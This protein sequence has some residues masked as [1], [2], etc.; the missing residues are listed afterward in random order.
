M[1]IKVLIIDDDPAMVD[2]LE[3]TLRSQ[4]METISACDGEK[5]ARLALNENPHIILLDLIMPG[6]DG[7]DVCKTIR[8]FSSAPIAV[9]SALSDPG[10]ISSALDA[11]ADEYLVKPITSSMLIAQVKKLAR[12]ANAEHNPIKMLGH[13]SAAHD[14]QPLRTRSA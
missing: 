9:L 8:K 2:M 14:T 12:R 11:G 7:W 5:G 6:K 4:G 1:P 13:M 10:I 3:V